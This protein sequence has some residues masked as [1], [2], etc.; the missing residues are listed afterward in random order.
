MGTGSRVG[1]RPAPRSS[2][3]R[4]VASH[5]SRQRRQVARC[6]AAAS[7]RPF[8][9][10]LAARDHPPPTVST[11]RS[12]SLGSPLTGSSGWRSEPKGALDSSRSFHSS[13][14]SP[15]VGPRP[16]RR[17]ASGTGGTDCP[18]AIDPSAGWRGRR[19]IPSQPQSG[20]Q[21]GRSPG[22]VRAAR[23]VCTCSVWA[24]QIGQRSPSGR[25]K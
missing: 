21:L 8:A 13:L 23:R 16:Q 1:M 24:S 12:S 10:L 19:S 4:R 2:P 18:D 5:R 17:R 25:M 20:H 9:S 14:P 11:G 15:C 7:R 3:P 22:S 6:R